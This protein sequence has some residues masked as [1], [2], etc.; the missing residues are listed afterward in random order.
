F[1]EPVDVTPTFDRFRPDYDW[2]VLATGPGHG[3]QLSNGRLIVPV[4]LSTGTGGHAHRPSVA[5]VVYSDD[6][7]RTWERGDIAAGPDDPKNPSETLAIEL[8]DGRVMLNLRNESPQHRRAITYSTDGATG[9]TPFVFDDALVEPICMASLIRLSAAPESDKNRILYAHPDSSEPRD[10]ARP[11][12]NFVRQNVS[13][14]LS[15]DEGET[16][17]VSKPLEPGISG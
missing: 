4:W 11:E 8:T 16:W 15:Y 7:G 12:S 3:I 1:T 10:P 6:H 17:P 14:K 2:K 9:G 5:S 13:V